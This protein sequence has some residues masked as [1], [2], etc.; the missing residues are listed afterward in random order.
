MV[1]T[2]DI[3]E[4]RYYLGD[5]LYTIAMTFTLGGLGLWTLIG[6]FLIRKLLETKTAELERNI[7]FQVKNMN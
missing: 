2:G 5:W 1:F 6:L 3:G 4:H 7:I